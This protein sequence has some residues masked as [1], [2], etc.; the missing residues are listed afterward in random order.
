MMRFLGVITGA[1][2]SRPVAMSQGPVRRRSSCVRATVLAAGL[3]AIYTVVYGQEQSAIYLAAV[4]DKGTPVLDL[5]MSDIAIKEDVGSSTIVSLRRFGWPLKVTV[6]VDNGPRTSDALVHYRT[7]LKKF[8]AGLPPNIPVSLIATA[9]NPRWLIRETTDRIQIERGVNLITI[10]EGLGRFSDALVE[11]AQRLDQEFRGIEAGHLPPYLPVLVSIATTHQD[12]SEV[13]R[14]DNIKMITS[15]RK[16]RVL[17]TMIMVSPGRAALTEPGGLPVINADEGQNAEIAKTVQEF[18][19]GR[20][21]PITGSGTSALSSTLLPEL[22]QAI[23]LRYLRQMT[24]YRIVFERPAGA[25]GPM[26]NFAL[27]LSNHPGAKI[28]VSTDG[29][30]P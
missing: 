25:T 4:D 18:T 28:V 14:D 24:Q 5:K 17:T 21:V 30:M 7:G 23:A 20:Y 12:G 16:H 29:A 13:R 3:A 22:A 10:D 15:L 8:F 2:S 6:L 27:S 19:R 11:Y 1:S 26:R 9:P